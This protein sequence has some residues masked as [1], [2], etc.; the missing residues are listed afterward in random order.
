M[1]TSTEPT[2]YTMSGGGCQIVS[3]KVLVTTCNGLETRPPLFTGRLRVHGEATAA[4]SAGSGLM[5]VMCDRMK[6]TAV[7]SGFALL[8]FE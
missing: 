3:S 2:H 1:I 7:I 6:L 4:D 8:V 5:G